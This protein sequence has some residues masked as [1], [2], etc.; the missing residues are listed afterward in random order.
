MPS[1]ARAARPKVGRYDVRRILRFLLA[2]GGVI[3]SCLSI[4]FDT[5]AQRRRGAAL[6]PGRRL[7]RTCP[8]LIAEAA[9]R[10]QAPAAPPRERVPAFSTSSFGSPKG[11]GA[12]PRGAGTGRPAHGA[13]T[14]RQV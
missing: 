11:H 10:L 1:D 7:E 9:E 6:S 13:R 12:R 4:P 8:S 2:P 14:L 3:L 5:S